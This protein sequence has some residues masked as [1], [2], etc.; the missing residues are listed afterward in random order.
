MEKIYKPYIM[1]ASLKICML[2]LGLAMT[3]VT[4]MSQTQVKGAYGGA[5]GIFVYLKAL[6]PPNTDKIAYCSIERK[7]SGTSEWKAVGVS[8]MPIGESDFTK[9][10]KAAIED[11]PY[12][13]SFLGDKGKDIWKRYDKAKTIDSLTVWFGFIPVQEALG[14]VY[15]D[16]TAKPDV[17]YEY[18]IQQFDV[19]DKS[20]QTLFYFPV[21]FPGNA[22]KYYLPY[23][24]YSA[25]GKQVVVTWGAPGKDLPPF[26]KVYR[27]DRFDGEWAPASSNIF[28]NNKNDSIFISAM[29]VAI[30]PGGVYRYKMIPMD[31]FGNPGKEA[32]SDLV[33]VYN[34]TM[35][36]PV[37]QELKATN[38][39]GAK[40][41]IVTWLITRNDLVNSIR[42]FRSTKY[43]DGYTLL[44][45]VPSTES[46]YL[47]QTVEPAVKYFYKITITGPMGELSVPSARVFAISDDKS[48]PLPPAIMSATGTSKG[49]LLTIYV[50]ENNLSGVRIFRKGEKE[51]DLKPVT[52][53]LPAI[54]NTVTWE[55]TLNVSGSKFYGYA[56]KS[57]NASHFQ[58]D[59]SEIVY[60]RSAKPVRLP[61]VMG[62]TADFYGTYNKLFWTDMQFGETNPAGYIVYRKEL[63]SGTMKP[64]N[65]TLIS[66]EV[67]SYTDRTIDG[68]KS[69]AYSVVLVDEFGNKSLQCDPVYVIPPVV[70][71]LA[72]A[73]VS[74]IAEQKSVKILWDEVRSS[75]LKEYRVYRYLRGTKA[76]VIGTI[77]AGSPTEFID[78]NVTKGQLIFYYVTTVDK[79][80]RESKPSEEISVRKD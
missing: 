27:K 45:E 22:S 41:T 30:I 72:P 39:E 12:D 26:A 19:N 2:L 15:H 71:V 5:K 58:G 63:P 31:I 46:S 74:G 60:A 33:A 7:E 28:S 13:L 75:T 65:D 49:I 47:D 55:D 66:A 44:A 61:V 37:I 56:A 35:E 73:S 53:L 59:F 14:V 51:T 34:F 29:D 77:P 64:L 67:N 78:K 10:L 76:A 6:A 3:S 25:A 70:P 36:A 40:G 9:R 69:Y 57:E 21:K 38:P 4:V 43:D 52:E 42:I 8:K 24:N 11:M 48:K 80:G 68:T 18:K 1:R 16:I 62:L 50:T 54:N 17:T 20:L 79:D 23:K 32:E